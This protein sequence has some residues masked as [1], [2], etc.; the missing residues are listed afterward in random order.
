MVVTSFY[1]AAAFVAV[2]AMLTLAMIVAMTA[3]AVIDM[4]ADPAR[5]NTD[6]HA[7]RLRD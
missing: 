1:V 3:A 6:S 4:H 2:A 7:L 5:A